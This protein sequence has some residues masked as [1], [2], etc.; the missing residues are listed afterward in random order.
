MVLILSYPLTLTTRTHPHFTFLSLALSLFFYNVISSL[1]PLFFH[2]VTS[3]PLV[4][5]LP[6]SSPLLPPDSFTTSSSLS[7]SS[8]FPP[9]LL[10]SLGNLLPA[11]IP[12]LLGDSQAGSCQPL[13]GRELPDVPELDG[14]VLWVAD[15]IACVTL[16]AWG[17]RR[18][19]F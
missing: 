9:L 4:L 6:F 7:S 10:T 17:V 2:H 5:Q 11:V 1:S 19:K 8:Q 14:L 16:A 15:Q 3:P 18:T 12:V 13:F